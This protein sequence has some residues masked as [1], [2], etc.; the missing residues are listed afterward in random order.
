M[1]RAILDRAARRDESLSRDLAA[2]YALS[3]LVRLLTAEEIQLQLFEVER[4]QQRF[5]GGRHVVSFR[6]S[7]EGGEG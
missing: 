6:G 1:D 3:L 7:G 5:Q 4:S 2:E